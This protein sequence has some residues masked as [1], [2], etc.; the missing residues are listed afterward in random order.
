MLWVLAALVQHF[1]ALLISALMSVAQQRLLVSA[2]LPGTPA[3]HCVSIVT[4]LCCQLDS[5]LHPL[6][7]TCTWYWCKRNHVCVD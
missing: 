7:C 4:W 3:L 2:C 5:V 6:T 1:L